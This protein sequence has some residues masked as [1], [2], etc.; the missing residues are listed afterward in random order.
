[1]KKRV[2]TG[3]QASGVPHLGNYFG[4]LKRSIAFQKDEN[5][6]CFYFIA[7]LHSFTTKRSV[8][9]FKQYQYDA[10]L[11]WLALGISPE[12][13]TFYRQSDLAGLHT[14]LAWYLSCLAPV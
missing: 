12:K 3:L 6:D 11:D 5:L 13:S 7:D 4:M 14:E 8:E 2:L 1:M 9:D 10:I